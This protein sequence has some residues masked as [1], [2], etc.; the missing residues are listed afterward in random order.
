MKKIVAAL[1]IQFFV[2]AS[3][4]AQFGN[5]LGKAQEAIRTGSPV[6]TGG[7]TESQAA[8]AIKEALTNGVKAGV[9]KVS[10]ADG[11]F[12][13]PNI[14]I[15]LPGEAAAVESSLRTLGQDQLV[16][17]TILQMNRSAEKAAGKASSIF[18]N[19]IGQMNISDAL[20]IVN[21]NQQDAATQY[22]KRTTTDQLITAFKPSIKEALD[23]THTTTL[24]REVTSIY[25]RIPLVSPVNT[26][27]PDYATRKAIDGLFYMIAQEEAKIRKDPAGQASDLIKKVFGSVKK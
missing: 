4:S 17:K 10:A 26:D 5:I 21:N 18:I 19:A 8:S 13:N 6:N 7:V 27:L 1:S 15:P 20:G 3:A 24:W 2:L 23:A 14:K 9:D 11:Y 22:L 12:G 16:D 25:N